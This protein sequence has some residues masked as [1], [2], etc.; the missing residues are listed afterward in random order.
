MDDV[1][2]PSNNPV[3]TSDSTDAAT[4]ALSGSTG[5][6][7]PVTTEP[8]DAKPVEASPALEEPTKTALNDPQEFE[9][10]TS[11]TTDQPVSTEPESSAGETV[12]QKG[13]GLDLSSLSEEDAKDLGVPVPAQANTAP[14]LSTPN[15]SM[16]KPP[17]KNSKAVI[18]IVAV[19]VA[20][21]LIAGAGYAYYTTSQK[22]KKANN[23]TP[24]VTQSTEKKTTDVKGAD[25]ESTSTAL[26]TSLKKVDDTKD[27]TAND[28]SDATLG[29]Q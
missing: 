7:I 19:L 3:N 27:F 28:L 13:A 5:I 9:S 11:S 26:D 18:I 25:I 14:D 1:K 23:N 17:K 6:S 2:R 22:N 8:T 4:A 10:P 12:P 15:M 24:A 29:L 20:L 21:A 16:A